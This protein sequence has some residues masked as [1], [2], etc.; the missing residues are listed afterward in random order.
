MIDIKTWGEF[1]FAF[2]KVIK[3]FD[4]VDD[5]SKLMDAGDRLMNDY[6]QPVFRMIIL[7]FLEQKSMEQI[8][9]EEK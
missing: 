1:M 9:S 2:W 8:R 4:T 3:A 6:P 5:F 7:G